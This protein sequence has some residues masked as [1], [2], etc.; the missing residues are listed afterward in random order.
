MC[1]FGLKQA[2]DDGE[3]RYGKKSAD[4]IQHDFYVDDGLKSVKTEDEAIMLI[5]NTRAIC[6]S[7]GLHLHKFVS[8]SRS[9]L[10]EIPPED[11]A[12]NIQNLDLTFEDL[13]IE[14]ALG[15]SWCIESDTFQ[16][17]INLQDKPLTRRGIL[18]TVSSIY[19]P[20]G[21]AAPV[22]LLGKQILQELCR[23]KLDWD[24]SIPDGVRPRL[25]N[26]GVH[27]LLQL[28]SYTGANRV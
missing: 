21:F 14:R 6:A 1:Q 22:V 25:G 7:A 23:D 15:I 11:Q 27:D 2:A 9:V 3:E 19:D 10:A 12:K 17:R 5:R 20:L 18:S 24:S 13:P 4:F 26:N 16:F 8:N 28:E